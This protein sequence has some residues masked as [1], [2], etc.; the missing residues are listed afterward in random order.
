MGGGGASLTSGLTPQPPTAKSSLLLP[1]PRRIR[2][3]RD[4]PET[5]DS[6]LHSSC[7]SSGVPQDSRL[8]STTFSPWALGTRTAGVTGNRT[9]DRQLGESYVKHVEAVPN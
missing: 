4:F 9:Q 5:V 8:P 6:G 2:G 3:V 1:G 7:P